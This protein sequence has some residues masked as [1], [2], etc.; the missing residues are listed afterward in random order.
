MA[1]CNVVCFSCSLKQYAIHVFCCIWRKYY[2]F[3][4]RSWQLYVRLSDLEC[5]FYTLFGYLYILSGRKYRYHPVLQFIIHIHPMIDGIESFFLPFSLAAQVMSMCLSQALRTIRRKVCFMAT[6][7]V[8]F[9][10][11]L[12]FQILESEV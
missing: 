1:L 8:H 9:F 2:T 6:Q 12:R 4:C 5:Y 7:S 11:I 3:D 10:E